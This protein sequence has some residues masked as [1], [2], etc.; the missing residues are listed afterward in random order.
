MGET[1]R[2]LR[3]KKNPSARRVFI[4]VSGFDSFFHLFFFFQTDQLRR[5]D[6]CDMLR[7]LRLD[8]SLV[9]GGLSKLISLWPLFQDWQILPHSENTNGSSVKELRSNRFTANAGVDVGVASWVCCGRAFCHKIPY[10]FRLFQ[11]VASQ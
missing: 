4:T 3:T 9:V 7:P 2:L 6:E 8:S 1:W 5:S 10:K 11:S